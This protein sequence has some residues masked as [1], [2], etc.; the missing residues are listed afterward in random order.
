MPSKNHS[1][2]AVARAGRFGGRM[3]SKNHSFH[4]VVAGK[5][6]NDHVKMEI[7]GR[8]PEGTRPPQTPPGESPTKI[9]QQIRRV[10]WSIQ[11]RWAS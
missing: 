10:Q 7:L 11:Q 1:F 6:G 3:P 4:V 8:R 2:L 9:Q 5:A